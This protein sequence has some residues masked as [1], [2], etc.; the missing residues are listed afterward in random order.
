MLQHLGH[1]ELAVLAMSHVPQRTAPVTESRIEFSE[2]AEASF[3]RLD[4]DATP[5][6]C[7]LFSTIPLSQPEA[8]LQF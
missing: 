6:S 2:R 5:A 7:T 3:A 1:A 8:T 4:P